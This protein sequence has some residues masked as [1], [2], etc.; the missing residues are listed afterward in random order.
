VFEAEIKLVYGSVREA[1]A[2]FLGVSPDNVPVP[3]GLVV[4][5]VRRG[6]CVVTRVVCDSRL[7]TFLATVDD[8]L[9]AVS[10]AERSVSVVE[11]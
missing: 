3:R 6:R 2:V 4:R 11:G 8:F 9:G 1:E 5:S 10:V 7:L